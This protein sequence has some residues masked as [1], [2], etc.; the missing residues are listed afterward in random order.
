[1][2]SNFEWNMALK[3]RR[4]ASDAAPP[5]PVDAR[6]PAACAAGPGG[7]YKPRPLIRRS[8]TMITA[9]TNKI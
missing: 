3:R 7:G 6:T 5:A 2:D 9:T 4:T 1:M 8:S